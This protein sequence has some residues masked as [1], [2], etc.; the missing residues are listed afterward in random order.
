MEY[1]SSLSGKKSSVTG[2]EIGDDYIIVQFRK[3]KYKYTNASAG[4][5]TIETMKNLALEQQGLSTFIA[6]NDPSYSSK[7]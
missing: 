6:Q 1:Y 3:W 7:Y 4:S 2:F 5:N